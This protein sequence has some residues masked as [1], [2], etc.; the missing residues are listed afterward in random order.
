[1]EGSVL[2]SPGEELNISNPQ[3][4]DELAKARFPR[5]AIEREWSR[6]RRLASAWILSWDDGGGEDEEGHVG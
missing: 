6:V 4:L 3:P 1:M 2:E 5:M